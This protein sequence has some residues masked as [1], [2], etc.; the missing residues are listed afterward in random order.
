MQLLDVLLTGVG[1]SMDASAVGM[2]NGLAEPEMKTPKVLLI[3]LFYGVFQGV[4]P[5]IG[6]FAS[7]LFADAVASVA[8]Y[9]ALIL[10]GFIGGKMIFEAFKKTEEE[11]K[12]LSILALLVQA[13]ATSVDALAVGVSLLAL[14]SAGE[15]AVN[16]FVC[17]G[18]FASV[19]FAISVASVYIGKKFGTVLADKAEFIGGLI[20][21][22]IGI[23]IFVEGVF[24]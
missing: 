7:G 8:P 16:V 20:L 2:S 21:V 3:A 18:I 13:I 5:L 22:I 23:K 14:E 19:T 6:Y 24:F 10:L 11:R 9:V 15:L 1:L 12:P 4:M 17:C